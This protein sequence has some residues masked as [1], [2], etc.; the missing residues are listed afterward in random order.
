ML[1]SNQFRGVGVA[2]VTPFANGEIDEKALKAVVKHQMNGGIQYLVCLGTTGESNML[3]SLEKNKVQDVMLEVNNASLPFVLGI[4]G[5]NN[6]SSQIKMLKEWNL[7]GVDA[8]L[9]AS[10]AYVKPSQEG[11]LQH[12]K[13]LSEASPLPII[14]YNV[15]GRTA[16]NMRSDVILMLAEECENIIGIKEASGDVV[17]GSQLIKHRTDDFL[18]ISGDD[19][20]ALGLLG[21]GGDGLISVIANAYP[22]ELSAMVNAALN[23]DFKKAQK[24]HHL[25]LDLHHWL[26]VEGNPTGIKAIL[27]EMNLS[28]REVRQPLAPLSEASRIKLIETMEKLDSQ[29]F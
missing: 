4:F 20:T 23:N 2:T 14:L 9:I 18:V 29:L 8:L 25:L 7:E 12:Y 28:T 27:E 15:P 26:Y 5:G 22:K 17:Q 21:C 1:E 19:P 6:T 11:I 16:S 3:S 24:Y 13:S 10:P